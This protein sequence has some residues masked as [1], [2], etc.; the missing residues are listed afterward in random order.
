[1]RRMTRGIPSSAPFGLAH[2]SYLLGICVEKQG[3]NVSIVHVHVPL[4]NN[5]Q[6]YAHGAELDNFIE[7]RQV[8]DSCSFTEALS[9]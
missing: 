7:R 5:G 8:V 1:M 2:V 4:C 6:D 9:N 3:F